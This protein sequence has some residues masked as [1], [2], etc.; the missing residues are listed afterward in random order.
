MTKLVVLVCGG[1]TYDDK[2]VLD[3][4]LAVIND[5]WG[6]AS[7][8]TGGAEGADTLA[9]YWAMENNIDYS[10]YHAEWGLYGRAAGPI[11][12]AQMLEQGKPDL[13]V[14]FPGGKGT[15]DMVR[16]SKAAGVEVMLCGVQA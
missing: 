2:G 8:I 15:Q 7:I 5:K 10:V 12:N 11:R 6:I 4:R 1:R 14:A 9:V 16:R 3:V 13:V